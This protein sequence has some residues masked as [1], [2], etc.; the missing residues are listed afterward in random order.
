MVCVCVCVCV[1]EHMYMCLCL[2]L[3]VLSVFVSACMGIKTIRET[4]Q[5]L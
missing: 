3:Y 5:Q 1:R 4:M 2:C